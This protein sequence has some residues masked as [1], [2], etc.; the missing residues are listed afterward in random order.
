MS[1]PVNTQSEFD[2]A[3]FWANKPIKK[4]VVTLFCRDADKTETRIIAA[5]CSDRASELALKTTD[6]ANAVI[7]EIRLATPEDLG[8]HP[9]SANDYQIKPILPTAVTKTWLG[10]DMAAGDSLTNK[11]IDPR[12]I[13]FAENYG[14][15]HFAGPA[16]KET[17]LL[18]NAPAMAAVRQLKQQ[19]ASLAAALAD[20]LVVMQQCDQHANAPRLWPNPV[21]GLE[22]DTAVAAA[23]LILREA[24]HGSN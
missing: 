5:G 20:C 21:G 22:W 10:V 15:S 16:G 19:H 18:G 9:V 14:L 4:F 1:Q 13:A 24:H 17:Y 2:A 7:R 11:F 12:I 8:C 6:L 3:M 23:A